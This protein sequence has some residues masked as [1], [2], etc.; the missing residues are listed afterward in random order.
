MEGMCQVEVRRWDQDVKDR[1]DFPP[2][3][4][5]RPQRVRLTMPDSFSRAPVF[6]V[7]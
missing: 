7:P 6:R 1:G 3:P 4:L 2:D 5:L